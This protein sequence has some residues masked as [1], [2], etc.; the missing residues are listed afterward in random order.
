MPTSTNSERVQ[1]LLTESL[2]EAAKRGA[3]EAGL[4]VS[5]FCR[6]LLKQAL[7]GRVGDKPLHTGDSAPGGG[8]RAR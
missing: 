6:M 8:D 4:S 2:A 1:V 5:S 7:L 3:D